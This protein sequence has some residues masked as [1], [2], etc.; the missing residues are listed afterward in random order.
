V[1]VSVSVCVCVCVCVSVC[2]CVYVSVCV[3]VYV[4]MSVCVCVCDMYRIA[5]AMVYKRGSGENFLA[6]LSFH[7]YVGSE[8]H[9]QVIRL[10]RQAPLPTK[11]WIPLLRFV[12]L[13]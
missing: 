3:C 12:S 9:T 11:L 6:L 1:C 2:V 7:T 4:Y 5:C 8:G 13:G 10:T